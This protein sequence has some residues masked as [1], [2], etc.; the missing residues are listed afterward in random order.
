M[1]GRRV[2]LYPSLDAL[3]SVQSVHRV[4]SSEF[5]CLLSSL[6]ILDQSTEFSQQSMRAHCQATST[7]PYTVPYP[8]NELHAACGWYGMVEVC[9]GAP[10]DQPWEV[11]VESGAREQDGCTVYSNH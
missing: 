1:H 3:R 2:Q 7:I 6:I 9:E 10:D 5:S 4:Q 8:A 11:C